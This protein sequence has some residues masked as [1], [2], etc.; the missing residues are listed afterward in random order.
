M[1]LTKG[2]YHSLDC[3]IIVKKGGSNM[4][5][6]EINEKIGT[7]L[8]K[9]INKKY[10]SVRQFG[11][12]C[13]EEKGETADNEA[14][15]KMSNRL[16]QILKGKKSVQIYDL[17]VFTKLLDISCEE[18]LSAGQCF[19]PTVNHLTNYAVA[20]S[21]DEKIWEEYIH[22]EDKIILNADEYG[23]TVI[24]YIFQFK[25]YEFLKHLISNKYIWFV[26]ANKNDYFSN[27]GAGTNI[28]RPS[29]F[30]NSNLNI[31][32]IKM[33]ENYTLRI[34]MILLAIENNDTKMLTELH[35]REIPSL[36][37]ACYLSSTPADCEKY[38]D[39]NMVSSIANASN[40]ILEYF[41]EEFE[42][43]DRFHH[44]NRFLFPYISELINLLIKNNNDYVEFLLKNVI[45]HNQYVY[46]KLTKLLESTV[47]FYSNQ[48]YFKNESVKNDIFKS[49][50]HYVSFYDNGNLIS[51]FD[52]VSK[53]GIITNIIQVKANSGNSKIDN[54]IKELNISYHKIH[55]I[56]PKA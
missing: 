37:Q 17:P 31:L 50:M 49:I 51:Y 3:T 19:S 41:S 44:V 14:L 10:K 9:L 22:R 55:S 47:S 23:K 26:G 46:D 24:D 29:Y 33:K 7:Y 2:Y 21:K 54:L 56:K 12:A 4:F 39:N 30:H 48:E 52:T 16:S 8:S 28:K 11:K 32:D 45:I 5:K 13:I 53:D 6:L 15:R 36:Y 43:E 27:F 34:N 1:Y 35:A 38:Y 18:L 25:N 20:F 40:E 42:I